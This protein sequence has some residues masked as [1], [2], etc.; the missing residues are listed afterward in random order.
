MR[1]IGAAKGSILAAIEPV[2]STVLSVVW[3]GVPLGGMDF[4]GIALIVAAMILL[5]GDDAEGTDKKT[6]KISEKFHTEAKND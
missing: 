5:A 3:L 6:R 4:A 1:R 2:A